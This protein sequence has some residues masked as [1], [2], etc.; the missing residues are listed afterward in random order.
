[1]V[2]TKQTMWPMI[3]D[4]KKI[5]RAKLEEIQNNIARGKQYAKEQEQNN[6][7]HALCKQKDMIFPSK[8]TM[9]RELVLYLG[10][11]NKMPHV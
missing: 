11:G 3:E 9:P 7:T 2:W 10:H 8:D 6:D 5:A 1:M 4:E